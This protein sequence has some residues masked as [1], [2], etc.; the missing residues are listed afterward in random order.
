MIF[1]SSL[2][3]PLLSFPSPTRR[4][5]IHSHYAS[6]FSFPVSLSLSPIIPLCIQTQPTNRHVLNLTLNQIPSY[7]CIN[8]TSLFPPHTTIFPFFFLL[9]LGHSLV[10]TTPLHFTLFPLYNPL[11]NF[12]TI[13]FLLLFPTSNAFS[14]SSLLCYQ[15]KPLQFSFSN[16]RKSRDTIQPHI[17]LIHFTSRTLHSHR[18]IPFHRFPPN[19]TLCRTT[20]F[21]TQKAKLTHQSKSIHHPHYVVLLGFLFPFFLSFSLFPLSSHHSASR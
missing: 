7:Y 18:S 19:S 14:L 8:H 6:I 12:P 1:S 13:G 4:C 21:T 20:L 15:T 3:I 11:S 17:V 2:L 16:S 10:V 5:L 9:F